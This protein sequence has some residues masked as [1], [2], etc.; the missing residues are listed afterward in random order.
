MRITFAT[1]TCLLPLLTTT[2]SALA[3]APGAAPPAPEGVASSAA[4][5]PT[6]RW[7]VGLRLTGLSLGRADA[8]APELEAGGAG[9]YARYRLARRWE[10]E[11]ALDQ[12][13]EQ[14]PAG[15]MLEG[16]RQLGAATAAGLFRIAPERA[17]TGYLLAGVGVTHVADATGAPLL[18]ASHVAL[19]GGVERRFGRFV[20]TADLRTMVVTEE[21][22][23]A[24]TTMARAGEPAAP[25]P[26]AEPEPLIGATFSL[27]GAY[28]F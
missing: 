2:S 20:L 22:A 8:E 10:L 19:G 1:A 12:G 5:A 13:A 7:T 26:A 27:A 3:Q 6:P 24:D 15:G 28:R 11:L 4:P 23:A 16:G 17:W 21:A 18:E 9:A 14:D 25:A